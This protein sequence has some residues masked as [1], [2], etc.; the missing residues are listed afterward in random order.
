MLT[1]DIEK[2]MLF[3]NPTSEGVIGASGRIWVDPELAEKLSDSR[4]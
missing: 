2:G 1:A 4:Q 3:P